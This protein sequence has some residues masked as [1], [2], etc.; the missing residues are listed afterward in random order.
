MRASILT[1][2]LLALLGTTS[3]ARAQEDGGDEPSEQAPRY[4]DVIRSELEAMQIAADCEAESPIRAR[5]V[6]RHRGRTSQR[7]FEISLV[8][9]DET[10]TVY[11]S[12]KRYLVAPA[13]AASTPD[14]LRRLMELNWSLLLGKFEWD[15]SSGEVRLAMVMNTDSNFDR[16][17][18]RSIAR[19]IGPVADRYL[20]ELSRLIGEE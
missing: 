8:Y 1:G 16:R 10:D 3:S 11:F 17:A 2:L 20:G 12:V 4:L 6:Y 19:A 13:D 15:P 14:V 5:C 7:D 18:F 9:S